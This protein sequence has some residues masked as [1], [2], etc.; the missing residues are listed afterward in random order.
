MIAGGCLASQTPCIWMWLLTRVLLC[1]SP[2]FNYTRHNTLS[3]IELTSSQ[4]V[5]MLP[6]IPSYLF[7]DSRRARIVDPHQDLPVAREFAE[8]EKVRE[9]HG[10]K[11]PV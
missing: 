1:L 9:T 7:F 10:E 2:T 5:F 4:R 3:K 11:C 8:Y 6:A